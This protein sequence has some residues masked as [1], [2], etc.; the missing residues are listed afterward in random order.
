MTTFPKH[1]ALTAIARTAENEYLVTCKFGQF[2]FRTPERFAWSDFPDSK[3][4][5]EANWTQNTT[6]LASIMEHLKVGETHEV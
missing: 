5:P 3:L 4:V 6:Y 2:R 1:I